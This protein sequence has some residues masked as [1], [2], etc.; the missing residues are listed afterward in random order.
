[1]MIEIFSE[2]SKNLVFIDIFFHSNNRNFIALQKTMLVC[3]DKYHWELL[4]FSSKFPLNYI[5]VVVVFP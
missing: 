1:M 3:R 5:G 2:A 4:L